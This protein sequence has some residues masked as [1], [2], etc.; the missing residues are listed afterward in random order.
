M[1]T[2]P[3]VNTYVYQRTT[4]Y[5]CGPTY[6]SIPMCIYLQV[7]TYVYLRTI[8]YLCVPTYKS[9][10]LYTYLQV[11]TCM[12]RP[13]S[14]Y[15]CCIMSLLMWS[16]IGLAMIKVCN[17]IMTRRS[18][19]QFT[20]KTFFIVLIPHPSMGF[21]SHCSASQEIIEPFNAALQ[22]R[23][24]CSISPQNNTAPRLWVIIIGLI[25]HEGDEI[26]NWMFFSYNNFAIIII[27]PFEPVIC[28][29]QMPAKRLDRRCSLNVRCSVM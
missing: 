2:C 20:A 13:R 1:S 23:F 10:P 12:Y 18:Y 26:V 7:N 16:I 15:K 19:C 3:T 17:E 9:I 28:K 25:C 22:N 24:A 4:Q 27:K 8:Q 29:I 6:K 11:S 21:A 14:Q 5:L